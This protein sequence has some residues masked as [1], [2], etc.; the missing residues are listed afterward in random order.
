MISIKAMTKRMTRIL[1]L[2]SS[3]WYAAV[4][5]PLVFASGLFNVL[6]SNDS[7]DA[8][9]PVQLFAGAFFGFA[10]LNY[11]ARGNLIGGIYS[12]PVAIANFSNLLIGGLAATKTGG[13]ANPRITGFGVVCLL[14]ATAFGVVLFRTPTSG[15]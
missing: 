6:L 9:L 3:I 13:F 14:F 8:S 1:M 15:Q 11:M 7:V 10:M 4:S 2:A 12:R 5:V